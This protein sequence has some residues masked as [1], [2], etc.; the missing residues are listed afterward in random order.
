MDHT[1]FQFSEFIGNPETD[2]L[3]NQDLTI[4]KDD[5]HTSIIRFL[6]SHHKGEKIFNLNGLRLE[7]MSEDNDLTA[8]YF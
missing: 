4:E 8:R 7:N 5:L 6:A 1:Y 3:R 2:S